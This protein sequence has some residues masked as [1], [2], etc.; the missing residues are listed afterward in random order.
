MDYCF[1]LEF[2]ALEL[3]DVAQRDGFVEVSPFQ[4]LCLY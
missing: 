1:D 2:T 4:F 3:H